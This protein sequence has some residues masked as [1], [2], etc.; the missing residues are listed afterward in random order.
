MCEVI[1]FIEFIKEV[2]FVFDIHL[3]NLEFFCKVFEENQGFIF[4]AESK[5]FS[6]RTKILLTC[7]RIS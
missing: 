4:V 2:S 6:P 3:P 7:Y 1:P 5:R